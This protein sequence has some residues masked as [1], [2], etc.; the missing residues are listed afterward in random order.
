M[1]Y[2]ITHS[3]LCNQDGRIRDISTGRSLQFEY[4]L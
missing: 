1:G 3:N 4:L 2:V